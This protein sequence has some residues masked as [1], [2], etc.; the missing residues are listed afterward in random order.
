MDT[1]ELTGLML[2]REAANR[3]V[4]ALVSQEVTV[5]CRRVE[6]MTPSFMD[7]MMRSARERHIDLRFVGVPERLRGTLSFLE[8][9]YRKDSECW[10]S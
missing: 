2:T 9:R 6:A 7:E 8:R 3:V 5:D 10:T 4:D 1:L